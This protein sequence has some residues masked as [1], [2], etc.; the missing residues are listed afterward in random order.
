MHT[1]KHAYSIEEVY[2][3]TQRKRETDERE[4]TTFAQKIN[5]P[6]YLKT[7]P[8]GVANCRNLPFDGRAMRDSWV[9]LP[10]KENTWS[11]QQRLFE[12]NVE[13]T[14]IRSTNF[15]CERFGSCIYAW[16]RY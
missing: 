12:E 9:R 11:R 3:R 5:R 2:T 10:R 6:N 13:K 7:V 16:G 1:L 14:K 15:K 4:N 8:S